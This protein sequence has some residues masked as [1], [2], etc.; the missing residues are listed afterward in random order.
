MTTKL[1]P[2][3]IARR[4][5]ASYWPEVQTSHKITNGIFEF[6]C[7]GHGGIV[8][9]IDATDQGILPEASVAAAQRAGL[10][11]EYVVYRSGRTTKVATSYRIRE[12]EWDMWVAYI[13][14]RGDLIQ[15]GRAWVG[16]EDCEW[17]TIVIASPAMQDAYVESRRGQITVPFE[18]WKA[19]FTNYPRECAQRWHPEY[20]ADLDAALATC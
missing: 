6:T 1:A 3:A 16:E 20:V 5:A 15:R 7:A 13:N 9:I 4:I 12:D 2:S 14:D 18:Q 17:S 10:V 19:E 8:A 11:I